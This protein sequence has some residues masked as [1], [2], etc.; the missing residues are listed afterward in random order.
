MTLERELREA[1]GIGRKRDFAGKLAMLAVASLVNVAVSGTEVLAAS[2]SAAVRAH[3]R[4]HR[5]MAAP[6]YKSGALHAA[7]GV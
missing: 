2:P 4:V 3:A 5:G 7:A 1:G 6:L